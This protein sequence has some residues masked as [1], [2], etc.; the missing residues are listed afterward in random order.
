MYRLNKFVNTFVRSSETGLTLILAL[1]MVA[2]V[3]L[4]VIPMVSIGSASLL[5]TN[6]A[7]QRFEERYAA[8]AGVE[9]ALWR[10]RWDGAFDKN[11]PFS[12]TQ[13]FNGLTTEVV[14]EPSPLP[15]PVYPDPVPSLDTPLTPLVSGG[16][17]KIWETVWWDAD[18]VG[19]C[20]QEPCPEQ[21][22]YFTIVVENYGSTRVHT[23]Q[24]G[25]CM[26]EGFTYREVVEVQNV[27]R[28]D[29]LNEDPSAP[30][31]PVTADDLNEP[32]ERITFQLTQNDNEPLCPLPRD[33]VRWDFDSP[34]PYVES[35]T[36]LPPGFGT[37]TYRATATK[38]SRGRYCNET[39][40]EP[41]PAVYGGI[42]PS[43]ECELFIG[44]PEWNISSTA[45]GVRV[46]ARATIMEDL[47]DAP[48]TIVSW[49]TAETSAAVPDPNG[50]HV[51]D[52]EDTLSRVAKGWDVAVVITVHD[53]GHDPVANATVEGVFR[54]DAWTS[55]D[56]SCGTDTSGQCVIDHKAIP[57]KAGG[58][59]EVTG[60][61]GI[62]AYDPAQN[63]DSGPD[64]NGTIIRLDQ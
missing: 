15:E 36:V 23:Q 13:D 8:D 4:I 42:I 46:N 10:I 43:G 56:L 61:Q 11:L 32:S 51:G 16:G 28:P 45:G 1:I 57:E 63:H 53:A 48:I 20:Y 18:T 27:W 62:L 37:I 64:S 47:D 35:R 49:Q 21:S 39:W 6:H 59:F 5:A 7:E 44:W 25:S 33:Q 40:A 22:F 9:D 38:L 52:L 54:V 50:M 17:I 55:N 24:F 29:F 30:H 19:P 14:I 12:N 58:T 34:L 3:S 41:N 26:P 2:A 31:L 60:L